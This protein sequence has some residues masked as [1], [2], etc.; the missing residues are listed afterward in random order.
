MTVTVPKVG[1]ISDLLTEVNEKLVKLGFCEEPIP[2]EDMCATDVWSHDINTIYE[3]HQAVD[4]IQDRDKTYIY[5]LRPLKEIQALHKEGEGGASDKVWDAPTKHRIKLDLQTMTKLNL[6]DQ[7]MDKLADYTVDRLIASRKFL[8]LHSTHESRMEFHKKLENFLDECHLA[9][10]HEESDGVKQTREEGDDEIDTA[11]HEMDDSEHTESGDVIQGL[12]DRSD[13]SSLFDNV[14]TKNDVAILEFCANKLRS[15]IIRLYEDEKRKQKVENGVVIQVSI[16]E[17]NHFSHGVGRDGISTTPIMLRLPGNATVYDLRKELAKR[18]CRSLVIDDSGSSSV[19]QAGDSRESSAEATDNVG[20]VREDQSV[21]ARL[22]IL[23]R[24]PLT[25]GRRS[26]SFNGRVNFF[27]MKQLGMIEHDDDMF[28]D[29]DNEEKP[30]VA[31]PSDEL[32]KQNIMAVVGKHGG[33]CINW[34]GDNSKNLFDSAEHE[35]TEILD[36]AAE[37]DSSDSEEEKT[38]V[39][40]CI[41]QYCQK[42]QLEETEM[43]YCNKCKNHVRA[44]KQF[45]LY[46]TPPILMVHLKRFYFSAS[47][48]RR[49]KITTKIDF[50]LKGLDLT[51]LVADYGEHNKPIYDCYGV[52]NHYGGLGGGHY[53][54]YVLNDEDGTWSY[55]D[56]TRITTNIDPKEVVSSAAYVLYYRRRDV[57]VGQD[58]DYNYNADS[59]RQP[60]PMSCENADAQ[61]DQRSEISSNNTAQA[62]DMDVT[63]DDMASNASSRTATSAMGSVDHNSVKESDVVVS[64]YPG[65][66]QKEV[67]EG[68]RLQ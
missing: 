12:V 67:D 15:Y 29:T 28:S 31:I 35:A 30:K 41:K 66:Q 6:N 62:G 22:Q 13:A 55:Y 37:S 18:L 68:Y 44:W 26:S 9:L 4:L 33:V 16:R 25:Y 52:S 46:R 27:G 38:T 8:P 1:K 64:F 5:Q 47:S 58:R 36:H 43:W 39:L 32:E 51:E 23:R 50:P 57:P 11:Q 20:A 40:D 17:A 60:S 2:L 49:D 3:N 24:T 53:T 7:W 61:G 14:K 54:A 63:L 48:H 59:S 65:D 19:S 34:D 21:D 42:E 10:Q 56:D 45:H